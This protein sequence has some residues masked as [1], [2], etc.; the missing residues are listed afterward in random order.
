MFRTR[1]VGSAQLPNTRVLMK[2]VKFR[3][4][5]A[6]ESCYLFRSFTSKGSFLQR[7]QTSFGHAFRRIPRR[8]RAFVLMN[9][10]V[11]AALSLGASQASATCGDYLHHRGH[12]NTIRDH[13]MMPADGTRAN[14]SVPAK[15]QPPCPCRGSSCQSAPANAPLPVPGQLLELQDQCLGVVISEV[16][17]LTQIS[18]LA[19]FS[20][21]LLQPMIA[22]RLDRPPNA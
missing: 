22:Y 13:S 1:A 18:P 21:P 10:V 15:E 6:T 4:Q 9:L 8:V 3:L 11:L 7:L 12:E 17:S 14:S 5:S 2:K 19:R 20:E 16:L